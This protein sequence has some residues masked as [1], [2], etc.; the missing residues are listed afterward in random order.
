MTDDK[1]KLPISSFDELV[2]IIKGYGHLEHPAG[3]AEISKLLGLG[4]TIIS[5]NAGFLTAT[6]I[7]EPGAKKQ[8]T[9]K[10]K[11][12]SRALEHEMPNEMRAAWRSV[13]SECDFL[14]RL[15]TAVKI[16]KGMEDSTLQAHIAYSAGQPKKPQ[17]MTGAR[18]IVDILRAAELVL[19]V[20][21][22]LVVSEDADAVGNQ[23]GIVRAAPSA[24]ESRGPIR[25]NDLAI[26]HSTALIDGVTEGQPSS[27]VALHV[28]IQLRID[29]K[30]SELDGLGSKIRA[31]I[32]DIS[33]SA[34][35][36]GK[37]KA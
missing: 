10:G 25:P 13:V 14:S 6:N 24:I 26:P 30:T 15:V 18:S 3:L 31:V 12:L 32:Q 9:P 2:K 11:E 29:C 21:G 23:T 36:E 34:G 7:L 35:E 33:A 28:N 19:E 16:R 27:N 37:P 20:D 8:V 4:T 1:F 22:K 17:V 5:A